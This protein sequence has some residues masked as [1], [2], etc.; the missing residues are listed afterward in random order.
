MYLGLSYHYLRGGFAKYEADGGF[1]IG[2]DED[3][4]PFIRGIPVRSWFIIL[5]L[6]NLRI[7]HQVMLLTWGFTL[8]MMINTAGLLLL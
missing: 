2:F 3:G 1:E 4:D 6:M 5:I 8:I 7:L